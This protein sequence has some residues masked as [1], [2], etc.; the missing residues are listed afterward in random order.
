LPRLRIGILVDT[1]LKL[2]CLGDMVAQVGHELG[3]GTVITDESTDVNVDSMDAWVVD[4]VDSGDS[5]ALE[6][7]H[8]SVIAALDDLLEQS[9]IPV[10]FNEDSE[11][12]QG[13]AEHSNWERRMRQRLE[14]LNGDVNLQQTSSASEVWV[15]GAS[16]GGPAAVKD[17]MVHL[18]AE[19]NVAFVYVQHIDKAQVEPLIK[20]MSKAGQ[21][22]SYL[23]TQGTVL[24]NNTLTL[25]S[26]R[27]SINIHENGTL[28]VSKN[29]WNGFYAP[30]IDQVAANVARVFRKRCGIIIFSGMGD[31]GAASCKL[32]KQQ[33]GRVWAQTPS[34]CVIDSMPNAAIATKTVD[35]VGTPRELAGAFAELRTLKQTIAL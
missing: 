23:A 13:S 31:D 21:Y 28:V 6:S 32:I 27:S 11:F 33:G 7:K 16:T 3:I 29:P 24:I 34:D 1:D 5:R 19:L 14:R 18:P 2:Q 20:M 8:P 12:Q 22:P 4:L 10:I 15:L 26:A 17:F 9:E 25:V 30:S 35:L